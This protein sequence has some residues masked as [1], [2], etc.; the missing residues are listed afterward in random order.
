MFAEE[1]VIK[2]S[3]TIIN[4]H[5]YNRRVSLQSWRNFVMY[6]F[7]IIDTIYVYT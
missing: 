7:H 3:E 6:V 1:K 4:F 5:R 2:Y